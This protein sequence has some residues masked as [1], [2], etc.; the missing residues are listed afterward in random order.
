MPREQHPDLR[1]DHVVAASAIVENPHAVMQLAVAIDRHSNA[2][3]V[4]GKEVDY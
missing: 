2:E 4:L 3:P 1:L